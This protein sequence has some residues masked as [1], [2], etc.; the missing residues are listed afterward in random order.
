MKNFLTKKSTIYRLFVL[1]Q[2]FLMISYSTSTNIETSTAEVSITGVSTITEPSGSAVWFLGDS[3][4]IYWTGDEIGTVK[5]SLYL[6]DTYIYTITASTTNDGEYQWSVPTGLTPSDYYQIKIEDTADQYDYDFSSYFTIAREPSFVSS[7]GSGDVWY[8]GNSYEII[9]DGIGGDVIIDLMYKPS[10][11]Y[12]LYQ[13]ISTCTANDGSYLWFVPSDINL[14]YYY[15]RVKAVT[16][17]SY[18]DISSGFTI[19]EEPTNVASPGFNSIW[20]KGDSYSITWT[21]SGG[22]VDIDLYKG[23][24]YI[25]SIAIGTA[26]DGYQSW[27]VPTDL[28]PDNDYN[29]RV[30]AETDHSI[31]AISADFTIGEE[32][33]LTIPSN[34]P[35]VIGQDFEI[36]W[37]GYGGN[38]KLEL[39]DS[40]TLELVISPSTLNDGNYIWAVPTH[41]EPDDNYRIKITSLAE[42]TLDDYS[43]YL[44]IYGDPPYQITQPGYQQTYDVDDTIDINWIAT[45]GSYV[46]LDLYQN[47]QF[48]KP[49][50]SSTTDDGS[51]SWSIPND[52]QSG[53]NYQIRIQSTASPTQYAYS[54]VFT[55]INPI[56]PIPP[57]LEYEIYSPSTGHYEY[58]GDSLDISWFV[59]DEY[60]RIELYKESSFN[61]L[62]D[63]YT[64]DDGSDSWTIPASIKPGENYR[65]KI[66]SYDNASK[67]A[68]S[69][70][71]SIYEYPEFLVDIGTEVYSNL[72]YEI[73]WSGYGG[74]VKIELFEYYDDDSPIVTIID[75]TENTGYYKWIVQGIEDYDT[76]HYIK[77]TSLEDE[78]EYSTTNNFYITKSEIEAKSNNYPYTAFDTDDTMEISWVLPDIMALLNVELISEGETVKL[79]AYSVENTG[80]LEWEIPLE[81]IPTQ[82]TY[83]IQITA[84]NNTEYTLFSDIFYISQSTLVPTYNAPN[85]VKSNF[86]FIGSIISLGGVTLLGVALTIFKF[87]G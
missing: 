73:K 76:L 41:L 49:I 28:E 87:K 40:Y 24:T 23:E 16:E 1:M 53:D 30:F 64:Y 12:L 38:V 57:E 18:Y 22:Y 13:T 8:L 51:F 84:T 59:A 33:I 56:P 25:E 55:I 70:Y 5:I 77:I 69:D 67:F 26:N 79:I 20:M 78:Y 6:D 43:D 19:A 54:S 32:P 35:I 82:D 34:T 83:Q 81:F 86:A 29:I 80:Y 4:Y 15:I 39:Y 47:S 58:I 65:V 27:S 48:S 60:V 63:S 52:L 7:P 17:S 66:I 61:Y 2:F 42:I 85:N 9:W 14:G 45:Y 75:S 72:P 44:Q 36:I 31:E 68:Y 46:Q 74:L 10:T 3:Y 37:S 71:F 11:I 62:I 50:T 21:G